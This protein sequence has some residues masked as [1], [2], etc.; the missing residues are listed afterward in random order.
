MRNLVNLITNQ[1]G[2]QAVVEMKKNP[3]LVRMDE[4]INYK[5]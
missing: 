1:I 5:S 4:K 2:V 3:Y